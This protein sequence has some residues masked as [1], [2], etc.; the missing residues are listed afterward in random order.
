MSM[1]RVVSCCWK[2]VFAMTSV[3]SWQNSVHLCPG[4]FC[5]PRPN[6]PVT[7]GISWLPIF[8]FQ[9]PMMKITF[10][11]FFLLV[12]V[13]ESLAG[14]QRTV[15]LLFFGFCGWGV[16]SNYCDIE[17]LALEINRNH[18][19]IFEIVHKYCILDS[20]VDYECY[21]ISFRDSCPQ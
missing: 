13:L 9:S 12:L 16:E 3:F 5:T 10:F 15:Q 4:S 17:W 6:L 7:P 2:K 1:C 18:S 14:L 21:S 19:V 20:S 8:A 11:F